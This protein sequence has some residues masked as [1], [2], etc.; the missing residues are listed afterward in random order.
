M[1]GVQQRYAV[2]AVVVALLANAADSVF[3]R[4]VLGVIALLMLA[5]MTYDAWAWLR[6]DEKSYDGE[7]VAR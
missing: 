7:M 6:R 4:Q 1:N 5:A 3:T 2:M